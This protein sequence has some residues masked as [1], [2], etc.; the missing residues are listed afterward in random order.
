MRDFLE[1]VTYNYKIIQLTLLSFWLFR[2]ETL[3]PCLPSIPHNHLWCLLYT[4][5]T[6]SSPLYYVIPREFQ[7]GKQLKAIAQ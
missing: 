2:Y 3:I 6:A 5:E 1:T 7:Q 4:I